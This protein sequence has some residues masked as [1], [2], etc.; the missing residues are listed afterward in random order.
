VKPTPTLDLFLYG[1]SEYWKRSP[2]YTGGTA[3]LPTGVGFGLVSAD[4]RACQVEIPVALT[5]CAPSNKNV[6]EITPGFWYRFYRGPA[7]TLQ[8]GM[9]YEHIRRTTWAG[10]LDATG[11]TKGS[12]HATQNLVMTSFR[13][14]FP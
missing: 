4:L 3:L 8:Y 1:G 5:A 11:A 10:R 14:Y 2:Y 6:Y 7:G 12:I 9:W 13:W